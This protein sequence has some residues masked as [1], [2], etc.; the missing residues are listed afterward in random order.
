MSDITAK[1]LGTYW[2]LCGGRPLST[3][4]GDILV[5]QL[6]DYDPTVVRGALQ[7]CLKECRRGISI[8]DILSRIEEERAKPAY[9][10]DF[11]ALPSGEKTVTPEQQNALVELTQEMMTKGQL[12]SAEEIQR[13]VDEICERDKQESEWNKLGI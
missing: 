7:R 13:R 5:R 6:E 4:A 8:G 11:P 2:E 10:H 9:H 1:E 3:E 12:V